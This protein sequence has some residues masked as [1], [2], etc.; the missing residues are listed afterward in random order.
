MPF[1]GATTNAG[2]KLTT[3]FRITKLSEEVVNIWLSIAMAIFMLLIGT[4][5][6]AYEIHKRSKHQ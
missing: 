4:G 2:H 6:L 3:I 1:G 5:L